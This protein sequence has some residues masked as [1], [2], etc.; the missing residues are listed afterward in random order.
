MTQSPLDKYADFI[1]RNRDLYDVYAGT[2]TRCIVELADYAAILESISGTRES[3]LEKKLDQL[4][5]LVR[6]T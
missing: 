2:P 5:E 3:V 4:I 1:Q 6:T